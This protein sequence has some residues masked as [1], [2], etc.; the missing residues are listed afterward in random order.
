MIHVKRTQI[1]AVLD[2][3]KSKGGKEFARWEKY[4]SDMKNGLPTKKPSEFTAYKDKRVMDALL[5]MFHKKCAYCDRSTTVGDVE[6]W[7][8]K[9]AISSNDNKKIADGYWWLAARW[10]NLLFSCMEC[11]QRRS[12]ELEGESGRSMAGKGTQFP[13]GDET[14]RAD[15][16]GKESAETPLLLNPCDDD[17]AEYMTV[18][19]DGD[20]MGVL[21][22][23][24]DTDEH[25][26]R[27]RTSIDIFGLNEF[28][29]VT[30]RVTLLEDLQNRIEY[31]NEQFASLQGDLATPKAEEIF[32]KIEVKLTQLKAFLNDTRENMLLIRQV[33]VPYLQGLRNDED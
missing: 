16:V 4:M 32:A 3:E 20:E 21:Q 24:L 1:P 29:L 27:A 17:P 31:L 28:S 18:A 8:P 23:L 30:R 11:N 14:K 22:P 13:L 33:V 26:K 25:Y 19:M 10:E 5:E 7:R 15:D 6:H 12:R 9:N 2:G